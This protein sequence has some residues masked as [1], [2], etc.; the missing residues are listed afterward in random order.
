MKVFQ[1]SMFLK[2][3]ILEIWSERTTIREILFRGCQYK[4]IVHAEIFS[5][6]RTQLAWFNFNEELV[7]WSKVTIPQKT[8]WKLWKFTLTFF[9]QKFCE[10]NCFTKDITKELIWRKKI[11]VKVILTLFQPLLSQNFCQ[12]S[13]R[14]I[15]CN[16][17]TVNVCSEI[18]CCLD[19]K[20]F[21]N[22]SWK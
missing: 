20:L 21:S 22:L 10:N 19:I 7:F 4:W 6:F 11:S 9:W 12:N 5:D 3:P 16:F 18:F 8:V 2:L 1:R 13:M 15:F 14:A 17:H